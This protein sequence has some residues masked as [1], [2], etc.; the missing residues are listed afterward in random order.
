MRSQHDK[1]VVGCLAD[2]GL[3][4]GLD[5]RRVG[6]DRAQLLEALDDVL[7]V[8]V[9]LERGGELLARRVGHA[10]RA[11]RLG[12]HEV[13]LE[14][15]LREERRARR[16]RLL[17]LLR[18][19]RRRLGLAKPEVRLRRPRR[20]ATNKDK[21][22]TTRRPREDDRTTTMRESTRRPREND[23]T[24]RELQQAT[25]E[26]PATDAKGARARARPRA[27]IA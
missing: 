20:D 5:S 24:N 14:P 13:R 21:R 8:G 18:L 23:R 3:D 11:Q 2:R 10:L 4:R 1:W 15:E 6:D 17:R 27:A 16:R 22:I 19:A 25:T 7:V 26:R 12:A 9:E